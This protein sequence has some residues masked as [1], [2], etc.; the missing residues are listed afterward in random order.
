[1]I[2]FMFGNEYEVINHP[3]NMP[4]TAFVILESKNGYMLLYNKFH[5]LWEITGGY[6]EPGES[7]MD[8]AIRECKEESNQNITGLTFVGVAKYPKMNAAVYYS[9]LSDIALFIE[10][11]EM[12]ALRWWQPNES[13]AEMDPESMKLI[14]LYIATTALHTHTIPHKP[15]GISLG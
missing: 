5:H 4:T 10:N 9:F 2:D 14:E 12:S 1:M 6:I 15:D 13:L 11:I 3:D 7:P 8:C